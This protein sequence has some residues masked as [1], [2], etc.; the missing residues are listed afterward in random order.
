ML[1]GFSPDSEFAANILV[2][3]LLYGDIF[4]DF[5]LLLYRHIAELPFHIGSCAANI[6]WKVRIQSSS[7]ISLMTVN[8]VIELLL[9]PHLVLLIGSFIKLE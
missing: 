1:D 5:D 8:V 7:I 2:V 6:F 9:E 3:M 4:Y